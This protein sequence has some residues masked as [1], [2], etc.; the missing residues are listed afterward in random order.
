MANEAQAHV[1]GVDEEVRLTPDEVAARY[2][3]GRTTVYMTLQ[4]GEWNAFS[5][6]VG[7]KIYVIK[8]GLEA[9][10]RDGGSRNCHTTSDENQTH[11]TGT[12]GSRTRTAHGATGSARDKQRKPRLES[13]LS[14][15]MPL[16]LRDKKPSR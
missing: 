6:R 5:F 15:P 13:L 2:G 3:L 9:W 8:S 1:I 16:R 10:L 11:S 14:G 7:R 12:T 4:R